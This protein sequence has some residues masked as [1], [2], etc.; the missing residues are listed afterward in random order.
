M[1]SRKFTT[2]GGKGGKGKKGKAQEGGKEEQG[3]E[4]YPV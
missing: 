1:S 2:K 3:I 4:E